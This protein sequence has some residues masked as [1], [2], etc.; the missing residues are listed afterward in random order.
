VAGITRALAEDP[1]TDVKKKAVFALSRL[2]RDRGVPLLIETARSNTNPAVRRQA[3]VWLGQSNDP[4]ALAY[5]A[6]VL[7]P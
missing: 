6:E 1:E 4:R 3:M 2:P 7:K 5:F